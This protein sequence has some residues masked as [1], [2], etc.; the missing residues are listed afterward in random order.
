MF[1][2]LSDALA[3]NRYAKTGRSAMTR[4][5]GAVGLKA[6]AYKLFRHRDPCLSGMID[7]AVRAY[8]GSHMK[9]IIMVFFIHSISR[10]EFV[11][12]IYYSE[13]FS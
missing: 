6:I 4:N 11:F 3:A 8:T 5:T 13:A 12:Q 10:C 1:E 7:G 9:H 2:T